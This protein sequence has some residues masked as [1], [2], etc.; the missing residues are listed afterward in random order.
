MAMVYAHISDHE[1]LRDYKAVLGPSARSP[2]LAATLPS[3]G[4]SRRAGL[5]QDEFFKT[6]LELGHCL[7]LPQKVPV[8]ATCT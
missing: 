7:R 2:V 6:E 1:V 3:G 8:S 5:D 4:L